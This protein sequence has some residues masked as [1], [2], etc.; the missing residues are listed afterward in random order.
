MILHHGKVNSITRGQPR[1]PQHDFFGPLHCNP[2]N[3]QYLVN[4]AEQGIESRLNGVAPLD[5]S[6]SVQYLL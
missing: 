1:I 5:R 6:E 2:V 4:D 3:R